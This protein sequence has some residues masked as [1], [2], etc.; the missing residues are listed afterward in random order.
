VNAYL[1]SSAAVLVNVLLAFAAVLLLG[2]GLQRW[3]GSRWARL[4]GWLLVGLVVV[5]THLALLRERAGLRMFSLLI[6]LC[7]AMKVLVVLESRSS[8]RFWNWLAFAA[9]WFGMQPKQFL[10]RCDQ[11]L[12]GSRS[13]LAQGL[14]WL[15]AGSATFLLARYLY[16]QGTS[17]RIA[18]LVFVAGFSMVLHFGIIPLLAAGFRSLGYNAGPQFH[19]PWRSVSLG[20][21]WSRRWNVA[22]SV[23][24]TLVVYR[25]MLRHTGRGGALFLGFLASGLFHEV[26]CS[27]PVQGGYGL[28]TLYFV[29]HGVG[30][31]LE[32]WLHHRGLRLRGVAATLWVYGW[33][34]VPIPLL[35]H[36]P[37]LRGLVLPLL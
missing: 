22:F 12:P 26:A 6:L 32:R 4:V 29:L 30:V 28:P 33:V 17:L 5:A 37:F 36:L 10:M 23:M 15:A 24:T 2:F 19:A 16:R 14:A 7:H 9:L 21:F 34:L 25:P 3:N 31:L 11:P 27:L 20:D 35:F 13:L 1:P 8:L 18:G